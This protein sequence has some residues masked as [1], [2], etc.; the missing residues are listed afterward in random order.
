M[1]VGIDTNI[2]LCSLNPGSRWHQAA[3]SFLSH[4]FADPTIRVAL[5]D[6]VLLELYVLLRNPAVMAKPLSSRQAKELATSYFEI[7]NVMRL[8]NAPI[9]DRVWA[10]AGVEDFPRRKVFNARLGLTL[11]HG[12]VTHFAT[13]NEKDFK[14]LGF[15]K[16]WNPLVVA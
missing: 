2:L 15:Q 12:G 11:L 13:T 6:Y 9:M 5:T 16:V 4:H 14:D 8:E 10:L 1:T 7:P 3:V